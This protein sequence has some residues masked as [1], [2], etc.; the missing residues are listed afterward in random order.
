[1]QEYLPE[2]MMSSQFENSYQILNIM[3]E[4]YTRYREMYTIKNKDKY[5]DYQEQKTDFSTKKS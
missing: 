5:I 2:Q 1:M 4:K 3:N